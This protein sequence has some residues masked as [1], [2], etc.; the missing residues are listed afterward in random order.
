MKP[1]NGVRQCYKSTNNTHKTFKD[2]SAA[3]F[4]TISLLYCHIAQSWTKI[5]LLYFFFCLCIEN[6]IN[7]PKWMKLFWG[8]SRSKVRS[9]FPNYM[10][11][12]GVNLKSGGRQKAS[13]I[14]VHRCP[15]SQ[16]GGRRPL[17]LLRDTGV[18]W[19][20][21]TRSTALSVLSIGLWTIA[22]HSFSR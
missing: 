5:R 16:W 8:K 21:K 7:M 22:S 1:Y 10:S 12:T 3:L 17:F 13:R 19:N 4:L 9:M 11:W 14:N 2:K 18:Q 20:R 15:Y 6:P